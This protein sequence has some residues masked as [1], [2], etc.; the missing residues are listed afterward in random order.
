LNPFVTTH[1]YPYLDDHF[2]LLL[3]P[4]ALTYLVY[5]HGIVL[6]LLQDLAGVGAEIATIWWIADILERRMAARTDGTVERRTGRAAHMTGP[7]VLTGALV[8]LLVDPWFIRR[9]VLGARRA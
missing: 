3:Y 5:P 9:A 7:A 2:G 1:R 8:L 4:I 6:L